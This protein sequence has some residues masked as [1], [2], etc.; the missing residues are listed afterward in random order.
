MI[1]K[2]VSDVKQ[3]VTSAKHILNREIYFDEIVDDMKKG[4][5][6]EFNI[7]LVNGELTCEE[8]KLASDFEKNCFSNR[9]WNHKR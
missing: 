5:E 3:R 6:K 7:D 8:E 2:L 9:E 1:D 4:F